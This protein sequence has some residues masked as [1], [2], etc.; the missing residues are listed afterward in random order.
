MDHLVAAAAAVDAIVDALVFFVFD[1]F[2]SV[3]YG[4]QQLVEIMIRRTTMMMKM[5]MMVVVWLQYDDVDMDPFDFPVLL[6][7]HHYH[8]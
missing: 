1:V 2:V 3:D 8:G 6:L 4:L 5:L 7:V